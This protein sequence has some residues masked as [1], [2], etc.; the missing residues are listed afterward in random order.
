MLSDINIKFT[1]VLVSCAENK[2]FNIH[3]WW[4]EGNDMKRQ[5]WKGF[6]MKLSK[7]NWN[8]KQWLVL[9]KH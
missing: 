6:D 4:L 9:E 7:W 2:T 1:Y 8:P 3:M 5:M